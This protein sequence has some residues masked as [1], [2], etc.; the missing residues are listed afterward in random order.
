MI[1]SELQLHWKDQIITCF[2]GAIKRR[3]CQMVIPLGN[4][5]FLI[6]QREFYPPACTYLSVFV[7][8]SIYLSST[9][10]TANSRTTYRPDT[11]KQKTQALTEINTALVFY[12]EIFYYTENK[13]LVFPE[14]F[15]E[16][17]SCKLS[18]LSL[19]LKQKKQMFSHF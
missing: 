4:K 16:A 14:P 9:S 7:H 3:L 1:T 11:F 5:F 10:L 8:K 13:Y 6:L 17:L 2:N 19:Y 12:F 15:C 18:H